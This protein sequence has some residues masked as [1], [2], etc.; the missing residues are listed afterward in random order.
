MLI[1]YE[2]CDDC[3]YKD[4]KCSRCGY[5]FSRALKKIVDLSN[6]LGRKITIL[7]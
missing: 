7:K 5:Y 3:K 4:E 2:P 6:E 1:P